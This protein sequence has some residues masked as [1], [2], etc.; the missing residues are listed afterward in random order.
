MKSGIGM[1]KATAILLVLIGSAFANP[2]SKPKPVS[3]YMRD[4]GILYLETVDP[5][6]H[7]AGCEGGAEAGV[8]V[9]AD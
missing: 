7:F 1:T 4:T 3:R 5:L 9:V 8:V 2:A 6:F